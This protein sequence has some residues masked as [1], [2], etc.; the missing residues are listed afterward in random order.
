MDINGANDI[1]VVYWGRSWP[2]LQS[3]LKISWE[4]ELEDSGGASEMDD[5]SENQKIT[6][7]CLTLISFIL[8]VCCCT[9]LHR[10]V[11]LRQRGQTHEQYRVV[12]P[13]SM[14]PESI[15]GV[16]SSSNDGV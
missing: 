7:V 16:D 6:I 1:E 9:C 15:P 12:Y 5:L 3:S 14:R 10:I 11:V 13:A 4:L 8:I 2:N